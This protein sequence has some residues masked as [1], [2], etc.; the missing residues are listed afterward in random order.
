MADQ[1]ILKIDK[2]DATIAE[3]IVALDALDFKRGYLVLA[4]GVAHETLKTAAPD[5]IINAYSLL[6][7]Q[8]AIIREKLAELKI[9]NSGEATVLADH[10]FLVKGVG[11]V[12]LG[13]VKKGVIKKHDEITLYPS[14][15]K[16]IV[17]SIQVHDTDVQEAQTGVRVGLALKDIKPEDI[18]RGTVLSTSQSIKTA[19]TIELNFTLSKYSP[20]TI[21]PGDIFLAAS[22]LN[23]TPAK[24]I[25]GSL[26][27]GQTGKIKIQLEKEIPQLSGRLL[28]LDP[29]QKMPRILGGGKI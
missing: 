29:G 27:P 25:E 22:T 14:K 26:K 4:E 16:T 19:S 12:V 9:D 7:W 28:L 24:T 18:P 10:S 15:T 1:C 6:E 17:K 21:N 2:L 11:T 3:T 23:Y 13:V 8:P 5:S 20:R